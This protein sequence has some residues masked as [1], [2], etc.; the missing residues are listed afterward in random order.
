MEGYTGSPNSAEERVDVPA[1]Y[2]NNAGGFSFG[3]G[4]SEIHQWRDPK[5]LNPVIPVDETP[6]PN[7]LDV[8]WLQFHS[9]RVQ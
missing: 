2:H 1:T 4:H 7:S 6:D 9:T 8:F 3:D 5:I